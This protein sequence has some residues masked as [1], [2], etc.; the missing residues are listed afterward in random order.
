VDGPRGE[1]A[2]S[3]V[4][5]VVD[6]LARRSAG[7]AQD[8]WLDDAEDPANWIGLEYVHDRVLAQLEHQSQLW[9]AA[10]GRLRLVLG[11]IG[12]VFAVTLGLLPR[13]NIT[14]QTE[15]WTP[16]TVPILLPFWVGVLAIG[17]LV[18]FAVAGGIAGVAYWPPRVLLAASSRVPAEIRDQ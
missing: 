4:R 6:S 11:I 18:L 17:G 2:A 14:V 10:D 8:H 15:A 16:P 5:A 13:G 9:E 12:I 3:L 7:V 1:L